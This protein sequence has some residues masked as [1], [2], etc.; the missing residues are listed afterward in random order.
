[1]FPVLAAMRDA[2]MKAWFY[3]PADQVDLLDGCLELLPGL[4][5]VLNHLGFLPKHA[6]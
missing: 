5:V 6:S 2:D 3:G 4:K 1:M